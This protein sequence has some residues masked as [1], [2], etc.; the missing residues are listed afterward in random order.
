[1]VRTVSF[2]QR[3]TFEFDGT[4]LPEAVTLGDFDNDGCNELCIGNVDG[5]LY[6]YKMKEERWMKRNLGMITC[7]GI[8]DIK[9]K[10]DN[11]LVVITGEGLCYIFDHEMILESKDKKESIEIPHTYKQ[12]FPLNIAQLVITDVSNR[13]AND[14]VVV[15]DTV[16]R[17]YSWDPDSEDRLVPQDKQS[18]NFRREV[19]AISVNTLS[20]GQT[21]LIVCIPYDGIRVLKAIRS[22]TG[23][24]GWE[25][26]T[27]VA[28]FTSPVRDVIGNIRCNEEV[29][30]DGMVSFVTLEGLLTMNRGEQE[31]WS[32]QL[33]MPIFALL[34]MDIDNDD[35]DEVVACSWDGQ[36]FF[37]DHKK[38]ICKYRFEENVAIRGFCAGQY[39]IGPDGNKPSLVYITNGH[40]VIYY[41][42]QLT[43]LGVQTLN[44]YP[45]DFGAV[46][47]N[48]DISGE[49]R[50]KLI[51]SLLTG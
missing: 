27:Q 2:V 51:R 30:E 4:L 21:I 16:V 20:D 3:Y 19:A 10:G 50:S 32:L 45:F 47:D 40:V 8:G 5:D 9:N 38:N 48:P 41:N 17:M 7:L 44:D 49:H 6:I 23:F 34:K 13:G 39:A 29:G 42:V 18:Y 12:K 31:L 33:D 11:S 25:P 22:E 28:K 43:S 14:L 1:M 46:C 15:L 26:V 35:N 37:V 36:T 24:E